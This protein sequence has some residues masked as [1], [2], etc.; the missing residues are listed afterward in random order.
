MRPSIATTPCPLSHQQAGLCSR[1]LVALALESSSPLDLYDEILTVWQ[2][3]G[4][5]RTKQKRENPML[6]SRLTIATFLAVMTEIGQ[7]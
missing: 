5:V 3:S 6:Y 2:D 7:L 1:M 4:S